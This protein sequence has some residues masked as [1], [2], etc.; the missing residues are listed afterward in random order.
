MTD[1]TSAAAVQIPA[2]GTYELDPAA[3]GHRAAAGRRAWPDGRARRRN[4]QT[5]HHADPGHTVAGLIPP[6]HSPQLLRFNRQA[7]RRAVST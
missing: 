2:A 5:D 4:N 6:A 1:T 3:A 7:L